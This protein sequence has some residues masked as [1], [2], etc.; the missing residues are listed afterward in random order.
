MRGNGNSNALNREGGSRRQLVTHVVSLE[1]HI[2]V[3]HHLVT[4]YFVI[5][6]D[7]CAVS[8]G[9]RQFACKMVDV[10]G[11]RWAFA[12]N[13]TRS[14]RGA[15]AEERRMTEKGVAELGRGIASGCNDR[16]AR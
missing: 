8:L 14:G 4:E 1:K 3:R 13:V 2:A 6:H 11:R 5:G 7:E 10:K 15:V 12:K 16:S 9:V